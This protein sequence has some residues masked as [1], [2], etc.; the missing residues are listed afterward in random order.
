MQQCRFCQTKLRGPAPGAR[1][2]DSRPGP[3]E[4]QDFSS[5]SLMRSWRPRMGHPAR[6]SGNWANRWRRKSGDAAVRESRSP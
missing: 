3:P 5:L 6:M 4:I 1:R 2:I